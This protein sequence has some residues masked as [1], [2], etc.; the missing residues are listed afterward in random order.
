MTGRSPTGLSEDAA[1]GKEG[2]VIG[3]AAEAVGLDDS[4]TAGMPSPASCP[5]PPQPARTNRAA[6]ADAAR[7]PRR[8]V[9]VLIIRIRIFR[10]VQ[11]AIQD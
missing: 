10:S 11:R 4:E 2:E 8:P 7:H 1:A 5:P 6:A 3:S 9:N